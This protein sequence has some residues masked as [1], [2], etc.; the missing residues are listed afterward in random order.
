VNSTEEFRL[1]VSHNGN[2]SVVQVFGE[3]DAYTT[4]QLRKALDAT[5]ERAAK[6]IVVGLG[7]TSFI[8][9]T[10]LG[11]M[12]A[13]SR[14]AAALGGEMVIDSP[15]APVYRILQITGLSLSILIENGPTGESP[16]E[17]PEESGESDDPGAAFADEE[18]D[19]G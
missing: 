5:L 4:P 8:D 17:S 19:A 13:A 16:D 18:A 1:E 6:R 3:L 15:R 2:E 7:G 11:A 12:V 9:S 10:G 14:R